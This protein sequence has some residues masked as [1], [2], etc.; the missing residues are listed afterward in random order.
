MLVV[1]ICNDPAELSPRLML[2]K[3]LPNRVQLTWNTAVWPVLKAQILKICSIDLLRCRTMPT[4]N[5]MCSHVLKPLLAAL[6]Q[7]AF[8][9]AF[10]NPWTHRQTSQETWTIGANTSDHASASCNMLQGPF[11]GQ[12]Q[13]G[14]P[15]LLGTWGF[16][17]ELAH[18]IIKLNTL[19]DASRTHW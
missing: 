17:N 2:P 14:S 15:I 9:G 12:L 3:P 5:C 13:Q 8:G 16:Q 18:Q 4:L 6:S 11:Q 7:K 19:P 10:I 1:V